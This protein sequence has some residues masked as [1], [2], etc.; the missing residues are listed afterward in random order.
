MMYERFSKSKQVILQRIDICIKWYI[1]F[2]NKHIMVYVS[3]EYIY[4]QRGQNENQ[5]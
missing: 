3:V 2:C 4:L 1:N 5:D